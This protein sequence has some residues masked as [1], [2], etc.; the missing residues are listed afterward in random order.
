MVV[1]ASWNVTILQH[2][3]MKKTLKEG[4]FVGFDQQTILKISFYGDFLLPLLYY[5]Y[6]CFILCL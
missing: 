6:F 3:L 1:D 4:T 5:E 2:R